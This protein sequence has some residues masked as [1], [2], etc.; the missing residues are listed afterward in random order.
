MNGDIFQIYC[1]MKL[2][3]SPF[4]VI[5][6]A[7]SSPVIL[8]LGIHLHN[9]VVKERR[10]VVQLISTWMGLLCNIKS[11]SDSQCGLPKCG[12]DSQCGLPR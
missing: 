5:V 9:K 8:L 1:I 3:F 7:A 4:I 11:S 6:I 2:S 12:W 10:N